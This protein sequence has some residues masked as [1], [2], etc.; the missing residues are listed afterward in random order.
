MLISVTWA[1]SP[2]VDKPLESVPHSQ[3]DAKPAVTFPATGHRCPASLQ[4]AP[5]DTG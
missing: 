4:L 2:Q 3:C 5:N 1:L